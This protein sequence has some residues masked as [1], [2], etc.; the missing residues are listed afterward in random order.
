MLKKSNKKESPKE[1]LH[2]MEI[3]HTEKNK[4][5]KPLSVSFSLVGLLGSII[6]VI[7]MTGDKISLPWGTA[8]LIIFVVFFIA[9]IRSLKNF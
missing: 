2:D 5:H 9:S 6:V 8:F 3:Y 7:L 1:L 4:Y